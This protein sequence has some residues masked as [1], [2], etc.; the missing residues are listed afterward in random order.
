MIFE[1]F[2]LIEARTDQEAWQ[3]AHTYGIQLENIDDE[4]TYMGKPATR[5]FLGIRKVRAIYNPPESDLDLDKDPPTNGSE[6]SHSCYEVN[7][8]DEA[9]KIAQG[10]EV[11]LVYL[12]E[13][14]EEQND[15][16]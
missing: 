6:L 3:K 13:L 15:I 16:I 1:D 2:Y 12:S 14:N 9:I 11:S 10:K 7:N 8:L 5:K 4:L